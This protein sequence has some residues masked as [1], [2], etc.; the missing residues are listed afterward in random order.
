M[1][2]SFEDIRAASAQLLATEKRTAETVQETTPDVITADII[3]F[4]QRLGSEPPR[5]LPVIDDPY[6]CYG[7]CSDGVDAKVRVAGGSPVFGWTIWEW[8]EALLTAEFHSV[9][10]SPT[11][12]LFDITPKPK[13]EDRIIFVP[14][15]SYPQNFNFDN[16]PR[17]QR[18]RIWA[19][20]DKGKEAQVLLTQLS[21][22]QHAYESR[23]AE[24]A[25]VSLTKWL[26]RKVPSDPIAA[27]IDEVIAA[28][29]VFEAHYDSL[30]VGGSQIRAD[31]RL[32]ALMKRK[33]LALAGFKALWASR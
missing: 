21:Q 1:I 19:D 11:N 27:A 17:N 15:P 29:D 28:S 8:P 31:A 7:W 20:I 6:G 30:G 32:L 14:D 33:E 18:M 25:G 3:N 16:R 5:F 13:G 10:K 22:S 9:W 12:D 4:A 24:R 23:R 26:E 2:M